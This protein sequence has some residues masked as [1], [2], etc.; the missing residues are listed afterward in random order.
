MRLCNCFMD[1]IAYGIYFRT[2]KALSNPSVEDIQSSI[3]ELLRRSEKSREE[4]S[5][6]SSDYDDARF[7]VIAWL[8][9]TMM[10]SA[11]T[12]KNDWRTN[13]LQ[14][15]Y[16]NTFA[17]GEEFFEK[18][19]KLE[20]DQNEIREVYHLCLMAGFSGKYTAFEKDD[21]QTLNHVI[22]RNLK[23]LTG[24]SDNL[25]ATAQQTLF[26]EAYGESDTQEMTRSPNHESSLFTTLAVLLG[27][28][29]VLAALFML[30]RYLL[31][32]E[33]VMDS[34]RIS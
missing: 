32:A 21:P 3:N 13:L 25:T 22:A 12:G 26:K 33:M 7:A 23:R 29:V 2:E 30:Y 10:K 9:E 20:P 28:I 27:P 8:D 18:L 11:W 15:K 14:R 6:S 24:T 5:L 1:L 34:L 19:E 4:E 17:A 16:Y 31:N